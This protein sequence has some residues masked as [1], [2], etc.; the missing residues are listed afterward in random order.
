[1]NNAPAGAAKRPSPKLKFTLPPSIQMAQET[2][3]FL[4]EIQQAALKMSLPKQDVNA[5]DKALRR[6][7]SDWVEGQLQGPTCRYPDCNAAAIAASHTLQKNGPLKEVAAEAVQRMTW[8]PVGPRKGS[9]GK[10]AASTFPGFCG[11]HEGVFDFEQGKKL[12]TNEHYLLQLYRTAVKE[13]WRER[14]ARDYFG[15]LPHLVKTWRHE[16]PWL[17]GRFDSF[18]NDA[19]ERWL[20]RH[21]DAASSAAE[22]HGIEGELAAACFGTPKPFDDANMTPQMVFKTA[23]KGQVPYAYSGSCHF[24]RDNVSPLLVLVVIPQDGETLVLM[25]CEQPF[26]ESL[27]AFRDLYMGNDDSIFRTVQSWATHRPDDWYF[28]S[29]WWNESPERQAE[30]LNKAHKALPEMNLLPLDGLN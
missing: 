15:E 25:T 7:T 30:T 9:I 14:F 23:V 19:E 5:S 21:M 17:D 18:V 27:R 11:K 20:N 24:W 12:E 8:K 1:M 22:L 2:E 3:D 4:R 13:N 28:S 16:I 10:G 6:L 29:D 26:G